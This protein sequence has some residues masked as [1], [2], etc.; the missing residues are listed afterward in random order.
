MKIASYPLASFAKALELAKT[1]DSLG[2]NCAHATCAT[3]MGKKLS[4]GF[5]DLIASAVKYGLITNKRGILS[6]AG[7]YK[8]YKFSYTPEE[9]EKHLIKLFLNPQL[10]QDIY[11]KYGSVGLPSSDVLEKALVREFGVPDKFTTRTATY[12]LNGAKYVGLLD[13]HNNFTSKV[14]VNT[15]TTTEH[16]DVHDASPAL[17]LSK[18]ESESTNYSVQIV[19]PSIDTKLTLTEES[20]FLILD[21]ILN[22]V[23]SKL[24]PE[25]KEK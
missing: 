12:F 3:K 19:G 14:P 13:E 1:V 10:F 18:N 15:A 5:K 7:E 4:G 16:K 6:L 24:T 8:D 22:K 25:K 11:A 20:D 17:D 9:G 23:R 2:D 21:A